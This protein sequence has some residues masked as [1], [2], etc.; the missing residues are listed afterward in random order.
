MWVLPTRSRVKNCQRLIEAFAST[1]TNSAVYVRLDDNDPE[2]EQMASLPWPNYC[3]IVIGPQVRMRAAMEEMLSQYP[4]EAWYGILADDA[5]PKTQN[6]D[7]R[8]IQAA[9]PASISYA[10]EVWEKKNRICF[11]CVGGDLV[12]YVGFFGLPGVE[13][14]GTDTIWER[15]HH[16]CRLDNKQADVVLEHAHFNFGQAELD[17]TYEG[18]QQ[19]KKQ[20]KRAYRAWMD[21]HFESLKHNVAEHFRWTI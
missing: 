19:L 20:D 14:W 5:I 18:T 2:L 8:L 9:S 6:W 3:E 15:L 11:P 12:R 1:K 16:E 17:T 13:H 7:Q 4:G 10:D 21:N